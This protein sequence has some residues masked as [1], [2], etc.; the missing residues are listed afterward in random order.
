MLHTTGPVAKPVAK[1][2]LSAQ[3]VELLLDLVEIKLSTV[4]VDPVDGRLP[5]GSL[6]RCRDELKTIEQVSRKMIAKRG[7][8]RPSK[9]LDS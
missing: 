8:G 3:S 6:E 1:L 4:G 7:P 9:Q 5:F 2:K